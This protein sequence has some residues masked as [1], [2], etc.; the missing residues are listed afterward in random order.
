ML[1]NSHVR[2][3]SDFAISLHHLR[4]IGTFRNNIILY[5]RYNILFYYRFDF[6]I[7][8]YYCYTL[9]WIIFIPFFDYF[10]DQINTRS[11]KHKSV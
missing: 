4:G 5:I 10:N 9:G 6:N 7:I 8:T 3:R 2:R 11:I 1:F